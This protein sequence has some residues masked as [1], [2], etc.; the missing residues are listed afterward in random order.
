MILNPEIKKEIMYRS[1]HRGC[2]ETD[3]LIGGFASAKLD[4]LSDDNLLLMRDF[5]LEDDMLIYDWVMGKISCVAKYKKIVTMIQDFHNI[6][7]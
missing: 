4:E 2:K 5:I 7:L 3:H 1:L 6:S